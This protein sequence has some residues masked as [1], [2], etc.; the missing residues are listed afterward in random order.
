MQNAGITTQLTHRISNNLKMSIIVEDEIVEAPALHARAQCGEGARTAA[1]EFYF[2]NDFEQPVLI[3]STLNFSWE[4]KPRTERITRVINGRGLPPDMEQSLRTKRKYDAY[5][6]RFSF[7]SAELRPESVELVRDIAQ[8]L[9]ANSEWKMQIA[10]HTD[11]TGAPDYN[12]GLSERRAEAVRLALVENGV[13]SWRL[14]SEGRGESQP[15]ADNDTLAGRA[16]NRRVEFSR[17]D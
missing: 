6:L 9:R 7:D 5:G 16:I 14:G 2:A 12:I 1:G 4:R 13:E 15:K 17:I 3:E 11:S 8:M 10:G